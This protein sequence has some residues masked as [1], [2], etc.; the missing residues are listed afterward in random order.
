MVYIGDSGLGKYGLV[1]ATDRV[2]TGFVADG[3]ATTTEWTTKTPAEILEDINTLLNACYAAAGYAICPS[4]LLL[5]PSQFGYITT[6]TVSTA[7]NISILK[8]VAENCIANQLNGRPL[9]IK[10]LKWLVG[11][12]EVAGSP[13]V[14]TDRMVCYTQDKI[15]VRFPLVPIQRTPVE[16]RSISHLTTYFGKLGVLEIVYPEAIR[17]A[18]GI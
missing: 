5:P 2:T 14:A 3:A 7:G 13:A 15:R 4:K 1:N 10:P 11:R 12:G 18:D 8:Y 9:D 6:Q 17:Y 16:Y